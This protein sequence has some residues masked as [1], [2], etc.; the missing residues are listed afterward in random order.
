M[1]LSTLRIALNKR[2]L[3]KSVVTV[4]SLITAADVSCQVIESKGEQFNWTRLRNMMSIGVCYYGPF[5]YYYYGMLDRKLP[6]K[7]PRTIA[8]KLLIDQVAVTIPS[9]AIFYGFI[10]AL[11]GKNLQ[12]TKTELQRKF[13]P[14]Y[15]TACLFWPGIQAVNFALVPPQFRVLMV[16][17][18]TFVWL[19]F[20]SFV[21]NQPTL[22]YIFVRINEITG[23]STVE[24]E[25]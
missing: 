21:K 6:G 22:P 4:T 20:L 3:L 15:V 17:T 7:N 24:V 9:L 18:S 14:T 10:S 19:T 1:V 13:L 12:E 11:E 8:L 25:Q 16:S 5:Y 23:A 2:P